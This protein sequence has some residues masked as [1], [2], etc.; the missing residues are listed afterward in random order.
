MR[1]L[2]TAYTFPPET[3]GVSHVTYA[4]ARGLA[5]KGH[6]VTVITSPARGRNIQALKNEGISV[7]EM[8]VKGDGN[9]RNRPRGDIAEYQER[10][11][12][13]KADAIL[14]AN[15]Q[16][17]F[18]NLAFPV[19]SSISAK[20]ILISHGLS[21]NSILQYKSL[22]NWLA[23]R[24]YVWKMPRMIRALDHIVFLCNCSDRDRFYDKYL[25]QKLGYENYSIIPNGTYPMKA[26]SDCNYFR[27]KHGISTKHMILHVANYETIKNQI[28]ALKAFRESEVEDAT[29]V[30]IG[31]NK[32]GYSDALESFAKR[33]GI[34]EKVII[35]ARVTREDI[36]N[37][38]LTADIFVCS[39]LQEVQPLVILDAMNYGVP[40]IS[41]DVGCVAELPGGI[42]CK[43]Q[44]DMAHKLRKL[45]Y[46]DSLLRSLREEGRRAC[47][48]V[49]SW[50]VAVNKYEHLLIDLIKGSAAGRSKKAE[51]CEVELDLGRDTG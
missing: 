7:I 46:D 9:M 45:I 32:N 10:I 40:F 1:L 44:A 5:G 2:F 22:L 30:F 24:P 39:S 16:T 4:H 12:T 8:N 41:T 28:M 31:S 49:Y 17:S 15:W 18:T 48:Q 25:C 51:S 6:D 43:T 20:K 27:N 42:T 3:N 11:S 34:N 13:F 29:I 33:K 21:V 26:E 37:A 36:I 23:W 35:L 38:Y 19:F 14:F 50:E 47:E